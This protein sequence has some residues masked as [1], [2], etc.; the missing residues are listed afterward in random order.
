[1][2]L[3]FSR[4]DRGFTRWR[5]G[6]FVILLIW[7]VGQNLFVELYIYQEQLAEGL[8]LSWAP[9]IPTGPWYNPTL[10]EFSGRTIQLQTQW[11]WVL[12]TPLYYW[13][14]I[15]VYGHSQAASK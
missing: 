11:P 7:F 14:L 3:C 10:F 5:W 13:V 9:L 6:A 4:T 12:M 8:R 15:R 1:M 2:W